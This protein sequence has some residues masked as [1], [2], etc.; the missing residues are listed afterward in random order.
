MLTFI[1][2]ICI[3]KGLDNIWALIIHLTS[4]SNYWGSSRAMWLSA[5]V[6]DTWLEINNKKYCLL[7]FCNF[8][9]I[10]KGFCTSPLSTQLQN[11]AADI[12]IWV[13]WLRPKATQKSSAPICVYSCVSLIMH[14]CLDGSKSH[15]DPL[16]INKVIGMAAT[17]KQSH[18][19]CKCVHTLETN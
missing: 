4:E 6:S 7:D 18:S 5:P 10:D 17:T 3:F 12:C 1:N 11:T 14:H 13:Q 2:T 9:R 19:E 8:M 16:A 15:D